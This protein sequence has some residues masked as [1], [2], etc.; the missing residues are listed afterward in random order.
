M[1]RSWSVTATEIEFKCVHSWL[2]LLPALRSC[3]AGPRGTERPSPHA[4]ACS[5]TGRGSARFGVVAPH[6]ATQR[7]RRT[8]RRVVAQGRHRARGESLP[9]GL[10]SDVACGF[11]RHQRRRNRRGALPRSESLQFGCVARSVAVIEFATHRRCSSLPSRGSGKV[12]AGLAAHRRGRQE[13]RTGTRTVGHVAES[14]SPAP[15]A[16][17]R[18]LTALDAP[19]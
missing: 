11:A 8:R 6:R 18:R 17:H 7:R 19:R 1:P 2:N 16:A 15:C 10:R 14:T 9:T 5:H 12:R 3:Y 13:M 4:Y